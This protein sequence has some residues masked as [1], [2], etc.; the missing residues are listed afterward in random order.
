MFTKSIKKACLVCTIFSLTVL[1]A[2]VSP[3]ARQL[4]LYGYISD[5]KC[6]AKGATESHRDCMEKCLAKGST[7]VLVTDD[8]H[9]LIR[10][11]NPAAVKGHYAHRVALD[12]YMN[13]DGFH[14]I[15]LRII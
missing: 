2:Q 5:S 14:V 10:I 13:N 4:T 1:V 7:I 9:R 8:D 6:A 11:D 15:S 12:G 3:G